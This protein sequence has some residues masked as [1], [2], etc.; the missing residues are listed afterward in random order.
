MEIPLVYLTQKLNQEVSE[1]FDFEAGADSKR[2]PPLSTYDV[3]DKQ[4]FIK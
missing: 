3:E 1:L 4:E 2:L